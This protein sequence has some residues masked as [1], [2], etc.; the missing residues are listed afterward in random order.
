MTGELHYTELF[1]FTNSIV[2]QRIF[3]KGKSKIILFFD[4]FTKLH[5]ARMQWGL[6]IYLINTTI[7]RIPEAS[8]YVLYRVKYLGETMRVLQLFFSYPISRVGGDTKR[9]GTMYEK[10][11]RGKT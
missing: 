2:F 9:F 4:I 10:K 7:A 11:G 8:I 5:T 6:I 1:V 3:Y